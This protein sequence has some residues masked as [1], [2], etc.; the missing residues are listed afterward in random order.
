M[1]YVLYIIYYILYIIYYI[2]IIIYNT[3]SSLGT[4]ERDVQLLAFRSIPGP[5]IIPAPWN[6]PPVPVMDMM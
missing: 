3:W 1:Y 5:R 4:Y 6:D 2:L